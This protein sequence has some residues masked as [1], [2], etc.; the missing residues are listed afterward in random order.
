MNLNFGIAKKFNGKCYMRFDDTNPET[1]NDEY[2]K[3]ILAVWK[4]N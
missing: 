3:A 4:M 1:E 2:I